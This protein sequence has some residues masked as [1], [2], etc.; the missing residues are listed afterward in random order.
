[1]LWEVLCKNCSGIS[2]EEEKALNLTPGSRWKSKVCETEVVL[3]KPP[4]RSGELQC[5]GVAMLPHGPLRPDQ[6]DAP[7]PNH[8]NGSLLGKRYGDQ[9]S[10]IEVLCTR[11]GLGSL[12]FDG[13]PLALRQAKPLPSS[14]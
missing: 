11:A 10:G 9:A 1:M 14:D 2:P 5:G 3:V 8:T 12:S 4:G 7:A 6:S 13:Q